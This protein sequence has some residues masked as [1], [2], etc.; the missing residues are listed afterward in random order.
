MFGHQTSQA[1]LQLPIH[2]HRLLTPVP[3]QAAAFKY[4]KFPI[5]LELQTREWSGTAVLI[6]M[7]LVKVLFTLVI[8]CNQRHLI[9]FHASASNQTLRV[10]FDLTPAPRRAGGVMQDQEHLQYSS[11]VTLLLQLVRS[12]LLNQPRQDFLSISH[13]EAIFLQVQKCNRLRCQFFL[14]SDAKSECTGGL[15]VL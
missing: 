7:H 14:V 12:R 11:G 8:P 9:A 3:A 2:G 6:L 10:Q 5:H 1:G 4:T 15:K 13:V